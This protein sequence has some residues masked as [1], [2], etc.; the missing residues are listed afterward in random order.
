M[1][2]KLVSNI[3]GIVARMR[4]GAARVARKSASNIAAD[5]RTS[6]GGHK[7][8]REYTRRGKKHRASA[9]GEAP[10]IETP[11]GGYAQTVRTAKVDELTFAAG[12]DDPRGPA[13]ELGGGR[14]AARPHFGPAFEREAENFGEGL[15]GL[16]E[17]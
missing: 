7:H 10:A 1:P 2:S 15:K 17:G 5:V 12:T 16:F 8:G 14:V 13:L 4:A 3:P 11:E 6:M 9:P